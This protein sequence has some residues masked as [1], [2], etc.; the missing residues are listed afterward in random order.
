[1]D[2]KVLPFFIFLSF[3]WQ[4]AGFD[5]YTEGIF[6]HVIASGSEAI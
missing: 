5:S 1:M 4:V 6:E 3:E 2:Y